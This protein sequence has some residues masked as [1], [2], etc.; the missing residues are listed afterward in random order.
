MARDFLKIQYKLKKDPDFGY[1]YLDPP[2]SEDFLKCFYKNRYY[3]YLQKKG[4]TQ[5]AKLISEDKETKNRELKWL[6]KTCYADRLDILNKHLSSNHKKILDV[7]CGSGEFLEFMKNSGW[8]TFGIEPSKEVFEK[9]K[10]KGVTVYNLTL[11][12]FFAQ[13][14]EK[15]KF[16]AIVLTNILEHILKPIETIMMAKELLSPGG[17]ICI[18]VPNDFNQ[19]QLLA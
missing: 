5:E 8:K 18:Q 6:Q 2:P 7:G 4:N 17:I 1:I 9:A 19:L 10:E 13:R 12:E 11:E 15:D 3:R 14:K 16:H